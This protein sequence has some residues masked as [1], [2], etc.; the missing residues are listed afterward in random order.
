MRLVV[1]TLAALVLAA[2]HAGAAQIP[3]SGLR[4]KV[5]RGPTTPVCLESVPCTAPAV[6]VVLQFW[7][8]DALVAR[9]RTG[10]AGGYALRLRAG[11][12]SVKSSQVPRIG[13]GLTPRKVRVPRERIAR[14]D[15][16]IDTGIR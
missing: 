14:V 9:V 15:F 3:S 5:T 7:R 11:V 6:G 12:Y 8:S 4:G 13:A 1:V 10:P 2:A 16:F